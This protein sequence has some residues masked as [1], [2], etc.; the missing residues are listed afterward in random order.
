MAEVENSKLVNVTT[1]LARVTVISA[2]LGVD[3]KTF[4]R[5]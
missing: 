3:G 4:C 1:G 5:I 2:D